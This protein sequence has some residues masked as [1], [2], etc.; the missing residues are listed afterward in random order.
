MKKLLALLMVV[1]SVLLVAAACGGDEEEAPKAVKAGPNETLII[2]AAAIPTT[3]DSEF[4]ASLES[5]EVPMECCDSITDLVVRTNPDGT[6]Q[7][8]P[9]QPPVCRM[10]ESYTRASDGMKYTFK[11]KKGIKSFYG[12]ELTTDDIKWSF[13]RKAAVKGVDLF[14]LNASS[15]DLNNPVTATDKYTFDV[16]LTKPN[17]LLPLVMAVP[18]CCQPWDS[19]EVKKHTTDVDPWAKEW[20]ATHTVGFGAY[21]VESITSGVEVIWVANPNYH[22]GAPRIKKVIYKQVPDAATRGALLQRGEVDVAVELSPRQ[23]EELRGKPGVDILSHGGN[24]GVMFGLNNK[25]PPLDNVKVRQ[26]IAYAAPI[27]EIKKS[28]FLNDASIKVAAGYAP[29]FY[30]GALPGGWPYTQ[31]LNKAKQLLQEAGIGPFSFKLAFNSA[32]PTHEEVATLLQTTL[33]PLGIDVV[34]DKL[35]PAKYQEQYFTR[36]ADAVLVQDSAWTPDGPYAIG[37]YF[38]SDTGVADWINYH[39][40]KVNQFIEQARGEADPTK[41]AQLTLD[42][43]KIVVDEAPWGFYLLTGYHLPKRTNVKGFIWRTNN[44]LRFVDFYKE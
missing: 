33:K 10:C 43:H 15:V 42:A 22:M 12:N 29:D 14:Q 41:R 5:W 1:V 23:R 3:L 9:L 40:A 28:V 25:L 4:G 38:S 18:S 11:L 7:V 37:L 30:P 21:H 32:R 35:S 16:N 36:K 26:A 39:N 27:S 31:D 44:L 24:E 8:D 34:L 2:A 6:R 17:P 13:E 20:M 19:K